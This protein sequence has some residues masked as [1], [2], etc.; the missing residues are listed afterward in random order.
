LVALLSDE[1]L[2]EKK[3]SAAKNIT[4]KKSFF[5]LKNLK[6]RRDKFNGK[7]SDPAKEFSLIADQW[8]S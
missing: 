4:G 3:I 6:I 7:I 8:G 5:I 1:L 2:Q